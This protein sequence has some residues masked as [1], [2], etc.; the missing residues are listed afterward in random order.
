MG[1]F[2]HQHVWF[3]YRGPPWSQGITHARL[4]EAGKIISISKRAL[5][6]IEAYFHIAVI[7]L[8][9]LQQSPGGH[10]LQISLQTSVTYTNYLLVY[11][12]LILSAELIP[13]RRFYDWVCADASRHAKPIPGKLKMAVSETTNCTPLMGGNQR[14][15]EGGSFGMKVAIRRCACML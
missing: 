9:D 4:R 2:Q 14:T 6:H 8:R 10:S 5:T 15:F 12:R 11:W 1:N 13:V 3:S 7:C